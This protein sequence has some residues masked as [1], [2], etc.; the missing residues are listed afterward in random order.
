MQAKPRFTTLP[1]LLADLHCIPRFCWEVWPQIGRPSAMYAGR[2]NNLDFF[3]LG[4]RAH[5]CTHATFHWGKAWTEMGYVLVE[6]NSMRLHNTPLHS[7]VMEP[8]CTLGCP[9]ASHGAWMRTVPC[10]ALPPKGRDANIHPLRHHHQ[11]CVMP[12]RA[13]PGLMVRFPQHTSLLH[14]PT[15]SPLL[16]NPSRF[17]L[18]LSCLILHTNHIVSLRNIALGSLLLI[19]LDSSA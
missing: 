8:R 17:V 1:T 7:I 10:L 4:H 11:T 9:S 16:G 15:S 2:G 6:S 18:I 5:I 12:I 13:C 14:R 3:S 19:Q